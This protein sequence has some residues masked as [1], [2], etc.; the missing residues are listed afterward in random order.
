[1]SASAAPLAGRSARGPKAMRA[2]A[3]WAVI[4]APGWASTARGAAVGCPAARFD[5]AG[6]P[7]CA[8]GLVRDHRRT[9]H[10]APVSRCPQPDAQKKTLHAAEQ[11]RPDVA[12]ARRVFIRRQP[13]LDPNRL[14]FI[15]E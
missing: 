10:G 6:D 14:V 5:P 3:R 8:C 1:M 13:A 9:E 2:R 11:D 12:Q 4:A 15:D 7:Q